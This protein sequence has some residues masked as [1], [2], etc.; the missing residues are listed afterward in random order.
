V[1]ASYDQALRALAKAGQPRDPAVTPRELATRLAG[2][3]L[4]G[5]AQLGELTELYYAAEWGGR[6]DTDAEARA[7]ALLRELRAALDAARRLPR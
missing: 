3:A 2:R 6:Q 4:A 5:A 1:A 7:Q